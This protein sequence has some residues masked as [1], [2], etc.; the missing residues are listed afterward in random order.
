VLKIGLS[1]PFC[2]K[3][4][5]L[6]KTVNC[7]CYIFEVHLSLGASNC[8]EMG[9]KSSYRNLAFSKHLV[10]MDLF[11][12]WW[13][14]NKY[15]VYILYFA[16]WAIAPFIIHLHVYI[17]WT[18]CSNNFEIMIFYFY[19][20]QHFLKSILAYQW[21][22]QFEHVDVPSFHMYHPTDCSINFRK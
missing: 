10:R 8:F 18:L 5:I 15:F 3:L 2:W 16:P 11:E 14:I 22:N 13:L 19:Q 4:N 20:W 9:L 7:D 17:H 1:D 6:A 12:T 21:C